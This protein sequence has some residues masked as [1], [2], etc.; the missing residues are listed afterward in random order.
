MW[1]GLFYALFL[2]AAAQAQSRLSPLTLEQAVATALDKYPGMR[3]SIEQVSAAAAQVELARTGFLPRADFLGQINRST[4]NNVFGMLFPQ[5]VIS[6][7][8]GPVLPV[9]S[10]G[11]VWGTAAGV[12]VSWEPFDFGLRSAGVKAARAAQAAAGAQTGVTRL[13]VAAATADAYLSLLAAHQTVLAA[14][15][16]VERMRVLETVVDA[17]VQ[18]GLRPG[19][20]ASRTR[21]GLAAAENQLIRAQEAVA[22]ARA[23]LASM[24][25]AKAADIVAMPGPML[26]LPPDAGL[27]ASSPA[28]HP[29]AVAQSASIAEIQARRHV[30]DRSYFPK[31][32]LQGTTYARGTGVQPDGATGGAAAGLGPNIQNWGIGMTVTFS[33]FDYSSLKARKQIEDSRQRSAQARYEQIIQDVAGEIAQASAMLDGA[34]R[35]AMNTPIQLEAARAAGRQAMA[36]YKAGLGGIVEVADAQRLLTQAEAEDALARLSVWRALMKLGIAQGDLTEFLR[37]SAGK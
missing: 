25:G 13:Q 10:L 22:V 7:I 30:L 11:S 8:S 5:P 12:L 34:R 19:V 32:N 6:P 4:H 17:L 26:E 37:K 16:G 9:H 1:M 28:A 20:E 24:M 23:A 3:V 35:V 33:L 27:A 14:E 29:V 36:R 21:A 18:N 2:V 15:G 31:F